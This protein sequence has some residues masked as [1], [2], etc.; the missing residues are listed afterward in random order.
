MLREAQAVV[1]EARVTGAP[2]D[3]V[4]AMRAAR[5]HRPGR[6]QVLGGALA[7]AAGVLLPRRSDAIG[8]PRVV[9][10]GGGMAGLCCAWRLW[11]HRGIAATIYEW[12]DR[13]GGRVQTL[14]GYFAHAQSAEQHG[15]FISSEHTA[16]RQLAK[17]FGLGLENTWADPTGVKDTYWFSGQ[18]YTQ[19]DLN[20]DWQDFGWKLFRD[21]VRK[22]PHANYQHSSRTAHAWDHMSVSEWIETY[23]PGGL[24]G[25]F[26]RLCLSDVIDEYGGPPE[27]Q[28]AL[29]LL[30]ILGYNASAPDGYQSPTVPLLAG[31][32]ERWH[33]VGGND[34]LVTALASRLPDGSTQLGYRLIA[35]AEN[36]DGS[37]TCTFMAASSTVEV[38]ADHVV[39]TLPFSTLRNV[40]LSGVRLSPRKRTAIA[41]LA[42]GNNAKIQI[43][44]AGRPWIHQGLDGNVLTDAAFDGG[45]DGTSYQNR[46]RPSPVEIFVALPGGADGAELA[47]KYGLTVGNPQGPAPAALVA[48]TLAQLEPIF[49]GVTGAWRRGPRLA[50][51]NDGN[52]D[53]RLLG[54][55]S[56]YNTG[57]YTGF[58]GIEGRREGNIHFAGEHTDVAYQGFIEGAVRS[59][60]RVAHEI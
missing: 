50:W 48:D 21:A 36:A 18:R 31:S 29:N 11:E 42:L 44:V 53:R 34:Q 33:V 56:Q 14:R 40:D 17:R 51:V 58:S 37:I 6:R 30:Y 23:V 10:V 46:G 32:D 13:L 38:V 22:A 52:I 59:G 35:L 15:E 24:T 57:Q 12:D 4:M 60:L 47:Q 39:L 1:H 49:P 3:E 19:K 7:T 20:R 8:Q 26:G 43:Q 28:S 9:I 2:V 25:A 5:A 55:W 16:T 27:N 41:S 45:W 54:A